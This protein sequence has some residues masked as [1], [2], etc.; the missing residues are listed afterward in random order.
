MENPQWSRRPSKKEFWRGHITAWKRSGLSQRKYC[1]HH[2]LALSSFTYWQRKIKHGKEERPRFY[3][4]TVTPVTTN[5]NCMAAA[6]SLFVQKER[7]RLEIPA[8]FSPAL[9]QKVI[10]TLE[11]L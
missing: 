10:A 9:L 11:Q 7:F 8:D 4:L 5:G 1:S 6:L 2:S 3:P